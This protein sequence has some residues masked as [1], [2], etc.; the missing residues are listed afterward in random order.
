[1]KVKIGN[2]IYDGEKEPVMIILS[3]KEKQEIANMPKSATK[4]CSYPDTDE[5]KGNNYAKINAWM[6]EA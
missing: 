2:K 5:W 1:M 3:P 6:R 4:Y